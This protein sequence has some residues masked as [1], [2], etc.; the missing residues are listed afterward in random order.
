MGSFPSFINLFA[1]EIMRS[2]LNTT[3]LCVI[4]AGRTYFPLVQPCGGSQ[5]THTAC[6]Q[7]GRATTCKFS[8]LLLLDCRLVG[9]RIEV[10]FAWFRPLVNP[11]GSVQASLVWYINEGPRTQ[12][13]THGWLNSTPRGDNVE[14]NRWG[15]VKPLDRT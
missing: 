1:S 14:F 5:T 2:T 6:E 4:G 3:G 15:T 13:T 12:D 8:F 11:L 9:R 7:C 10:G